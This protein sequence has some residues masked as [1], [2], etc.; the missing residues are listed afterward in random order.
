MD[1]AKAMQT[2]YQEGG[3]RTTEDLAISIMQ[4][5]NVGGGTTINWTTCFRTPERFT[6]MEPPPWHTTLR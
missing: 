2:L 4:G 1:E 3:L 5:H 6:K